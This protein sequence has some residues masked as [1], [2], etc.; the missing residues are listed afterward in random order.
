MR[1]TPIQEVWVQELAG[2]HCVLFFGK[3]LDYHSF[4]HHPGIEMG[5]GYCHENLMKTYSITSLPLG[6]QLVIEWYP[7][8]A[9]DVYNTP[10]HYGNQNKL[11]TDDPLSSSRDLIFSVVQSVNYGHTSLHEPSEQQRKLS[12]LER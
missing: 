12:I 11:Q 5:T 2:G 4:S 10:W 1:W 9:G 6:G 7:I 3:T 8:Q